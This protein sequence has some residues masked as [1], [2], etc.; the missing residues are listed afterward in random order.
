V[1]AFMSG[2]GQ[3]SSRGATPSSA[4]ASHASG[5]GAGQAG[6]TIVLKDSPQLTTKVLRRTHCAAACAE[7]LY[8]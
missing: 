7:L 5:S 8:K 1:A 2:L 4:A 3:A 6:G